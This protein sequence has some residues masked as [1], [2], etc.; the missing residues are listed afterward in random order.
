MNFLQFLP[1]PPSRQQLW[2][3]VAANDARHIRKISIQL[4]AV[5]ALNHT[6][7]IIVNPQL[8]SG[9]N[10][11]FQKSKGYTVE[12]GIFTCFCQR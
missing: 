12:M 1:K 11:D 6:I 10:G 7:V 2:D 8:L 3:R 9:A 4:G 5:Q